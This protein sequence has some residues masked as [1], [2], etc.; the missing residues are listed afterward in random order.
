MKE[1]AAVEE[2]IIPISVKRERMIPLTIQTSGSDL[3]N[4]PQEETR[5][6]DSGI[7]SRGS[8]WQSGSFKDGNFSPG[9]YATLPGS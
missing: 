7:T 4:F 2:H 1:Q 3:K 9:S 5:S 6:R 8:S